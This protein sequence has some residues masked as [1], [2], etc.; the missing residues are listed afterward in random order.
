MPFLKPSAAKRCVLSV[1]LAPVFF[2]AA[3]LR[4]QNE[5]LSP[6]A[7][8]WPRA[9]NAAAPGPGLSLELDARRALELGLSAVAVELY[10]TLL[11]DAATGAVAR[12]RASLDL[13]TALIE[14]D[15]PDDAKKVLDALTGLPTPASRLRQALIAARQGRLDFARTEAQA[16]KPDELS[17]LDR[18]WL[19]FLRGQLADNARDFAQ[20][21]AFYQQ[22]FEAA[23]AAGLRAQRAWFLLARERTNLVLGKADEAALATHRAELERNVGRA[24]GYRATTQ[25]AV[26]LA[27]LRRPAEAITLLQTQLSLLPRQEQ[28]VRDEWQLLLGLIAGAEE[29]AGRNA[30]KNLLTVSSDRD[31]QRAALRLLA[32]ASR[33]GPRREDLRALLDQLIAATPTHPILDDLLLFRAQ[34]A[35]VEKGDKRY[36]QAE[37]DANRLLTEFPGSPLKAAALGVLTQAAWEQGFYRI[38]ASQAA[39]ARAELPA[40]SPRAQLGVLVAEAYFRAADYRTAVDAYGA[41][42]AEVPPGVSPGDLIFQRVLS[43]IRADQFDEAE[44]LLDASAGDA[45]LDATNRWQAEWNLARALQAAEATLRAYARVNRLLGSAQTDGLRPDLRASMAWLQARLSLESNDLTR[46]LTLADTLGASLG[47]VTPALRA[48]LASNALLLQAQ[49]GFALKEPARTAAALERLKKLRADFPKSDAAVYSFIIEADAAETEGRVVDA[50]RLLRELA[51]Q[52]PQSQHAPYALYRA[53][54]SVERRAPDPQY[55][56][57]AYRLLEELVT[58]YPQSD[59]VF[60]A[61]LR[62]G[63]LLR[64]LNE[65]GRASTIYEALTGRYKFPQFPDALSAELALADTEATLAASDPSRAGSAA[66]RYAALYDQQAAPIDLRAEAGYKLGL[67]RATRESADRAYAVWWPMI[68]AFVRDDAKAETLGARGRYWTARTILKLG[69]LLERQNKP[70][71]AREL[72]DLLLQKKLP[73]GAL[74]N[75]GL[76]RTG[77]K[78]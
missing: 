77:G 38:A 60:Y 66:N 35:I 26:A 50:Q 19:F 39:K 17:P 8:F 2:S 22:A 12:A 18:G 36:A 73:G 24:A 56:N 65:Y 32:R 16:L 6:P 7:P 75:E 43:A 37:S 13:A 54:L 57:E 1:L 46:T 25:L 61:R 47:D 52:F 59:L 67:H 20:A 62:Q 23:A 41:A 51:D 63:N 71:Q 21:G 78:S 4:A 49:A 3:L 45:R 42:L 33:A 5:P 27:V 44:K 40:G 31:R 14:E 72:Y 55:Y 64:S 58:E 10:E 48:D 30:L 69:E 29:A 74:A 53:A 34:I 15:R 9:A 68:D 76:A 28:G 70:R 11:A